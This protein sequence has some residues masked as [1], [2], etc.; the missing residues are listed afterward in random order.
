MNEVLR[1]NLKSLFEQHRVVF[2]YNVSEDEKAELGDISSLGDIE[3]IELE[4]ENEFRVKCHILKENP[5]GKILFISKK[6][7]PENKDNWLLDILLSEGEFKT[8]IVSIYL[9]EMGLNDSFYD[10][11]S[12]Y[13]SFFKDEKNREKLKGVENFNKDPLSLERAAIAL[14]VGLDEYN[15]NNV[16]LSLIKE[17]FGKGNKTKWKKLGTYS[18]ILV[19]LSEIETNFG[20]QEK[21]IRE[22]VLD[23]YRSSLNVFLEQGNMS[24]AEKTLISSINIKITGEEREELSAYCYLELCIDNLLPNKDYKKLLS[25]YDYKE[26][27]YDIIEIVTKEVRDSEISSQEILSIIK[28]RE[29]GYW[30]SEVKNQYDGLLYARKVLE[31]DTNFTISSFNEGIDKYIDKWSVVDRDYRL[32]SECLKND[33]SDT[34]RIVKDKV[35]NYYVN[36]FL[37]PLSEKWN[38]YVL[39]Y[40]NDGW[41]EAYGASGGEL[42]NSYLEKIISKDRTAVVIISDAM[43]YEIGAELAQKINQENRKEAKLSYIIGPAPSYTKLGMARLLPHRSLEMKSDE[44]VLVDSLPSSGLDDRNEILNQYDWTKNGKKYLSIAFRSEVIEQKL[45][46][47]L[48]EI[49]RDYSVIYIYQNIIDDRANNDLPGATRDAIN[50]LVALVTKLTSSNATAIFITSD[51]GF[52]WQNKAVDDIDFFSEGKVKGDNISFN[53]RFALGYNL[54]T[55]DGVT[56]KKFSELGFSNKDDLEVA[57]PNSITKFRS[58]GEYGTFY[59]GGLTLEEIVV[60]VIS[61]S[62][63]KTDNVHYVSLE[64]KTNITTIRM[65]TVSLKYLQKEPISDKALPYNA[66]VSIYSEDG[67]LISDEVK[68]C[69]NS[70]S[71]EISDRLYEVTLTLSS[72]S[73]KYKNKDVKIVVNRISDNNRHDKVLTTNVYLKGSAFGNDF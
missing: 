51:H 16:L 20:Y 11:V 35:D 64:L 15:L 28:E 49:V 37:R 29:S 21:T 39:G 26:I 57:F 36:S 10:V 63:I 48:K 58:S 47:E 19:L 30:Y 3:E 68:I 52:I 12:K 34:L 67:K 54:Q 60:P 71:S 50:K 46:S 55:T 70:T 17:E 43:R 32:F 7:K 38:P 73:D 33:L 59:H 56:I 18:F 66:I 14:I 27:D 62:Q 24:R 8:D 9:N 44:S 4:G 42:A 72:L 25:F 41:K 61:V 13:V 1:N 31:A 69:I 23:L 22:F 5:E 65:G 40:L 6:E 53:R 45:T 2:W